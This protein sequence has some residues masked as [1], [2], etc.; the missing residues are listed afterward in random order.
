MPNPMRTRL[1]EEIARQNGEAPTE[2]RR[3]WL[4]IFWP[5]MTVAGAV[6]VVL[7]TAAVVW[8]AQEK[9]PGGGNP[10]LAMRAPAAAETASEPNVSLRSL[11]TAPQIAAKIEA[12]SEIASDDAA[13][14][15]GR[16][17]DNV[18]PSKPAEEAR[19]ERTE[20]Q[21]FADVAIARAAQIA[22]TKS[23]PTEERA[24]LASRSDQPSQAPATAMAPSSENFAA[25]A[26]SALAKN[27]KTGAPNLQQQ[28]SQTSR[29]QALRSNSKLKPAANILDTF[30]VERDGQ[31]IRVVDADGST[32]TGKFEPVARSSARRMLKQKEVAPAPA[33]DAAKREVEVSATNN[34]MFFRAAGYNANLKKQVVFEGNYIPMQAPEKKASAP[35]KSDD[36]EQ[37]PARIV[38]QAKVPGEA[39]VEIDAASVSR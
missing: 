13:V 4:A 20:M 34:E 21:K 28:F 36:V 10:Q 7:G 9:N 26:P 6:A 18:T 14:A 22:A 29:G 11:D 12:R 33:Q 35:G 3:S 39:P 37:V 1:Q 32:Y 19:E 2:P 15:G 30:Q 27:Q 38:G 16:L 5:Q 8:L 24:R 25:A 23:A 17:A 31:E